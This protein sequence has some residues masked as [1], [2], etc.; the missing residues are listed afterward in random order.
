[1]HAQ[2]DS[3]CI[4]IGAAVNSDTVLAQNLGASPDL[5]HTPPLLE[6]RGAANASTAI[7]SI[8][9][10]AGSGVVVIPHQDVYLPRGFLDRLSG[11]V[12][13]LSATA[14]DWAVLGVVGV[15]TSGII[16]GR[17]WSSGLGREVGVPNLE[18]VESVSLDE[19]TLIVRADA[20][21]FVDADLPGFHLYGTD[22]VLS[23]RR[24]GRPSF[25]VDLPVVHNSVRVRQLDAGYRAAYS[26]M[27][28][29]WR[30]HLPLRTCVVPI[31]RAPW[32][33]LRYRLRL[34]WREWRRKDAPARDPDPAAIARRLGYERVEGVAS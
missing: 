14:P 25:V 24:A 28:R 22:I 30:D 29:K 15:D 31:E 17:T 27:A 21:E 12:E 6:A 5:R 2:I 16:R 9:E 13:R 18:P 34:A 33:L 3:P 8:L 32:R 7:R 11:I 4:R 10:R 20:A 23:A 26:Y 1:M 19:V